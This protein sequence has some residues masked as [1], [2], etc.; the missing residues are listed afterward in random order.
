VLSSYAFAL[1]VL[2]MP[3]RDA[4]TVATTTL[5]AMGLYLVLVLEAAG[6]KRGSVVLGMCLVLGGAYIAIL[7]LSSLRAFFAL[8]DPSPLVLV[9]ALC[10]AALALLGLWMSDERFAPGRAVPL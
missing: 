7:A 2:D 1:H 10:G 9:T 3:I 4:R 5:V 6:R 8:A